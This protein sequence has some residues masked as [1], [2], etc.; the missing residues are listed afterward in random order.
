MGLG[1]GRHSRNKYQRGQHGKKGFLEEV[2]IRHLKVGEKI[3]QRRE[4]VLD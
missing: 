2:T 3:K 4:S 1:A